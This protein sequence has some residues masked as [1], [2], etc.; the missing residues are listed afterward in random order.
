VHVW[1]NAAPYASDNPDIFPLL[2]A[3]DNVV[4]T[5]LLESGQQLI[6]DRCK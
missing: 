4:H 1:F 5:W 6:D 3:E 2:H